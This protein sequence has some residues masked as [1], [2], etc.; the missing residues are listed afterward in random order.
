MINTMINT[1]F[2]TMINTNSRTIKKQAVLDAHQCPI[3]LE[4]KDLKFYE[5]HLKEAKKY[6]VM[7]DETDLD[8]DS[9]SITRLN[10]SLEKLK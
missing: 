8:S 3:K 5:D 9:D 7:D 6:D 10:I 1:M 2:N 4:H